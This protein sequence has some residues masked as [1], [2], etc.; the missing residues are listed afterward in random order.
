VYVLGLVLGS[1][2][3]SGITA[4]GCDA[5]RREAAADAYQKE[6]RRHRARVRVFQKEYPAIESRLK[7]LRRQQ[8]REA[9]QVIRK[10]LLPLLGS[11]VKSY[12]PMIEKGR[13]YVALLPESVESRP[14]LEAQL[15]VFR[16][17][18]D[19]W[20]E[21]RRTYQEEARLLASGE[22]DPDHLQELFNR[23]IAITQRM[24]E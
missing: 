19:Q 11:L 12:G 21:I 22:P 3:G 9:A 16:K 2:S 20:S 18:R 1:I 7:G 15:S 13:A 23:R 5:A 17:R 14:T 24:E 6:L 10:R 8:P 4:P